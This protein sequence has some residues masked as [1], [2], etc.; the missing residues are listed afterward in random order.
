ME[1]LKKEYVTPLLTV[2]GDIGEI[3]QAGCSPNSDRPNG[4]VN[5]TDAYPCLPRSGS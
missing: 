3:T 5:D 1:N 4:T 2:H